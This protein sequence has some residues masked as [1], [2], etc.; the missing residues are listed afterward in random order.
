MCCTEES[1]GLCQCF[2][3]GCSSVVSFSFV[4]YRRGV[5]Y[6]CTSRIYTPLP[7]ITYTPAC[8]F[9]LYM[10]LRAKTPYTTF[11]VRQV[12]FGEW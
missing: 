9:H 6:H 10:V 7:F 5:S 2:W 4:E 11:K 12:R 8:M 3:Y 1:E